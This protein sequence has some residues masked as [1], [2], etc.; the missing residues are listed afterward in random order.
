VELKKKCLDPPRQFQSYT[1]ARMRF[2]AKF[3]AIGWCWV[4]MAGLQAVLWLSRKRSGAVDS[5]ALGCV[6]IALQ[7]ALNHAFIYWEIG[8]DGLRERRLWNTK[9]VPWQEVVHVGSWHPKNTA[10][11]YLEIEYARPAPKSDRGSVIANPEDRSGF[12][13]ALHRF[14]TQASFDV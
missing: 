5:F 10:S 13:A 11:D 14:A 1:S 3:G 6:L 4:G 2:R 7:Q 12:L 8:P 9:E